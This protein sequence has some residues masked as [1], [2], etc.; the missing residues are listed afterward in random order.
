MPLVT[1]E[2][3]N[4]VL[5][6]DVSVE[7]YTALYTVAR[8]VV[9]A[10]FPTSVDALT[11]QSA[12]I[13]AGVLTSVMA[14]ILSNPTGARTLSGGAAAVTFGGADAEITRIF[15]LNSAERQ[16]LTDAALAITG[17]AGGAFSI[18]PWSRR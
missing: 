3:F 8:R 6:E 14:R 13:V 15:T 16:A 5:D 17:S 2:E 7:R 9:Q 11:G 1:R 4:L 12:E 18:R 10:A